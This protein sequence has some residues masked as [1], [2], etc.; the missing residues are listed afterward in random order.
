MVAALVAANIDDM[1]DRRKDAQNVNGTRVSCARQRRRRR[2][3]KTASPWALRNIS[4]NAS[5]LY[6]R[7][8]ALSV[9]GDVALQAVNGGVTGRR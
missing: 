4:K 5:F 2:R 6:Q 3:V 8:V 7:A 1:A 9:S